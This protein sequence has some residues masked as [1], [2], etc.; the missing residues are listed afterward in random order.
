MTAELH[1]LEIFTGSN[2]SI[3]QSI[4]LI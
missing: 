4:S 2:Q 1:S 3:S